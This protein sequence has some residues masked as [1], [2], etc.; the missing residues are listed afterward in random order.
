MSPARWQQ[1]KEV[2]HAALERPAE[3]R[4]PLVAKA[5][6]DDA[7]LRLEVESLL[8]SHGEAQ[9]FLETTA[10]AA[11]VSAGPDD[12]R[13]ALV[14]ARIGPYRIVREIGRGGMGTVYLAERDDHEYRK[15]VAIKLIRGD[16]DSAVILARFRRERQILAELDHPNIARL[17]DGGTTADGISYFVMEHVEGLSI[18]AHCESRKLAIDDRL[19]LVRIVC[20]AVSAAHG[21]LVIHR[22]LKPDNILVTGDGA[23]KLLDFGIAKLLMP[24]PGSI[25]TVTGGRLMTPEYASP[26]QWRGDSVTEASDIYSLGVVL[27][28][29]LTG[30]GPYRV[31]SDLPHELG[32]AIL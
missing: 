13:D 28:H 32:R 27:Y 24:P 4:G 26:E 17:L 23:P 11:V 29:L 22:D 12:P 15:Q 18:D 1:I 21:R 2:L 25:R 8:A 6:G 31:A 5:C 9:D 16:V 10:R 20:S 19:K 14:G 30:R 3:E 7:D